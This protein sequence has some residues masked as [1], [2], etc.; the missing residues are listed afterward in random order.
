MIISASRRTDV[1]AFYSEWLMNRIETG[2]C[3]VPNPLNPKQVTVV[4]LKPEDVDVIVFWT[5][6]PSPLLARLK[7]LDRR[8]Y[9][10]LFLYTLTGNPRAMEPHRPSLEQTLKTFKTLSDRIG[11]DRVTWRYDPLVFTSATGPEFHRE[12]YETIARH[13]RGHTRRSIM[14]VVKIYRKIGQRITA[15]RK[16]GIELVECEG[17]ALSDLLKFM[18][19]TAQDNGMTLSSCAQEMDLTSSGI[20]P[21]KCIDD[22][23]IREVFGVEVSRRKDPSQRKACGCVVSKDIGMYDTCVYGCAYCYATTSFERAKGNYRGHNPESAALI[24]RSD[25]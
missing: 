3:E 19:A 11:P 13:L 23:L 24:S 12:T 21:G 15:L 18:A 20:L 17:E 7:E 22:G 2:H 4:S 8:G 10:C 9:R 1:P 14:S 25:S 5:R 16:E 6:N